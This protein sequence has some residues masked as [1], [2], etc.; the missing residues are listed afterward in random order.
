MS[1]RLSHAFALGSATLALV[2][3]APLVAT[4]TTPTATTPTAPPGLGVART[5]IPAAANCPSS[6]GMKVAEAPTPTAVVK[7]FGH[8]WGHGMGMSQYGAQGAARLGCSYKTILGTYYNNSSLAFRALDAPVLLSLASMATTAKLDAEGG[9]V[10]WVSGSRSAVQPQGTTWS[11]TRRTV[12]GRVGLV[13]LDDKGSRKMFVPDAGVLSA[14][15]TGT[16]VKV[17]PTGSTSGLRSRWGNG[18]FIGSSAG[19]R[20]AEVIGSGQDETAVQKYLMGLAEVPVSWP[21]EALKAQVVAARTYLSSKYSSSDQAYV[22][23]T[24]TADQV[25]R[26]YDQE[27]A[28]ARLGGRWHQAVS[29]TLGKV[30]VDSSGQ[31]IEAMYSSSMGGHTEN[32]QYVYGKYGI[33]YLKAVDDSRWDNAS[34]NPYRR[35]SKGFSTKDLAKRFGFDSVSS[36]TVA[37]RGSAARLSGVRITGRRDG[38]TVTVAFTGTQARGKLGLRSPGFVFGAVPVIPIPTPAPTPKPTP[39]PT[40][41]PTPTATPAPSPSPTG[42]ASSGLAPL[43]RVVG[44]APQPR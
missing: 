17:R 37:K 21:V 20:V 41:T 34:D 14:R 15:H 35:W 4:A 9:T 2:V 36:W 33:S 5:I 38:K 27:Q 43:R 12:S 13:L 24:T 31:T 7:V 42:P 29:A 22:L 3:S 32:R 28:D 30:I 39:K 40:P 1:R 6:G 10:R 19:V 26:G 18:R 11:V 44:K 16:V 8:G 25:Y 23:K